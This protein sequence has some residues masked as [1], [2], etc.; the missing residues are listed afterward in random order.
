VIPHGFDYI[1]GN[2]KENSDE[3]LKIGFIGAVKAPR[4][5]REVILKLIQE[6]VNENI[7]WHFFGGESNISEFINFEI[8]GKAIFHGR[9]QNEEEIPKILSENSIDLVI[10]PSME[11]FSIVLSEVW[12][13]KL[14]VIVPD[15]MALGERVKENGGGWIIPY[16]CKA[17]D[18][19]KILSEIKDKTKLHEMKIK[20]QNIKLKTKQECINEYIQIYKDVIKQRVVQ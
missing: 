10:L 3:I 18:I 16:P 14:P 17:N 15:I 8:K 4:K 7:E 9:Y 5:G 1:R 6:N 20:V 12:A 2:V 11:T 13:A 19:L